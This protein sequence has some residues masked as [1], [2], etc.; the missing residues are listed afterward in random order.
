VDQ[1][2]TDNL[3]LHIVTEDMRNQE[4][5]ARC[6][7]LK[8]AWVLWTPASPRGSSHQTCHWELLVATSKSRIQTQQT[9][10]VH[11]GPST[12]AGKQLPQ[13]HAAGEDVG[14]AGQVAL[15]W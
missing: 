10:L 13:Q 14:G 4:G 11:A 12:A 7:H 6:N 8:L 3:G 5:A 15:Y 2:S 1:Y 9:H